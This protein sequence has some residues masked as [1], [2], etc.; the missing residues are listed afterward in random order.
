M[1]TDRKLLMWLSRRLARLSLKH[2]SQYVIK[3]NEMKLNMKLVSLIW[4]FIGK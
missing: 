1:V 2:S 3:K 4:C